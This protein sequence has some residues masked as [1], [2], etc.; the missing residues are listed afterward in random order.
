[1]PGGGSDGHG[2]SLAG[3]GVDDYL[4]ERL[5]RPLAFGYVGTI[6]IILCA[7]HNL[8]TFRFLR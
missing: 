8:R 4:V 1:M 6:I 2:G 5:A 3:G 7:W